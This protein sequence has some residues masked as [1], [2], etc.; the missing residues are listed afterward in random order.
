MEK[1]KKEL[2]VMQVR[3]ETSIAATD[4]KTDWEQRQTTLSNF[5]QIDRLVVEGQ[6]SGKQTGNR[7]DITRSKD[8][9]LV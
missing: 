9:G 3:A 5:F 1:G 2:Q 7:G 8:T 6:E 4:R